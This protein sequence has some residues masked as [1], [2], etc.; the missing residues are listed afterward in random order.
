MSDDEHDSKVKSKE[1]VLEGI[2]QVFGR[3]Q[4]PGE[5][6]L[7]SLSPSMRLVPDAPLTREEWNVMFGA[8]C[9]FYGIKA[10]P[11]DDPI[12]KRGWTISFVPRSKQ[13]SWPSPQESEPGREPDGEKGGARS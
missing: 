3:K 13:K 4:E 12:Y 7:E 6:P 1:Q 11:P 5:P 9:R 2:Y 8:D 10:A